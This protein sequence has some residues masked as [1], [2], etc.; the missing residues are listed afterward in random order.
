MPAKNNA[1]SSGLG[2]LYGV[3]VGPGSPD[4]LT[5]RAHQVLGSV[6]AVFAPKSKE[7]GTSIALTVARNSISHVADV[8]EVRFPMTSD[9]NILRPHWDKAATGALSYLRRGIDVAFVTLGD[10]CIYSTFVYLVRA[11]HAEEADVPVAFVPGVTSFAAASAKIGRILVEGDQPLTVIPTVGG[12]EDLSEALR[13][14]GSLVLMK[15]GR[16][17]AGIA[18]A[19]EEQ[20]RLSNAVIVSKVGLPG[21]EIISG[22]AEMDPKELKRTKDYL[23]LMLIPAAKV[24]SSG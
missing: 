16:Q 13:G 14:G 23:T 19:L 11:V 7:E 3:G 6:G 15:A 9:Q 1:V 2:T 17:I 24:E 20:G 10:P 4:L 8:H 22:L 21:E 5:L 12:H 18:A